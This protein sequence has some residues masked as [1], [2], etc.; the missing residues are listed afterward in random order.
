MFE[1]INANKFDKNNLLVKNLGA[2]KATYTNSRDQS[3][4]SI[5]CCTDHMR[6]AGGTYENP[7]L[8]RQ[9]FYGQA[10]MR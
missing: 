4:A 8:Y 2:S 6:P 3:R 1:K 7:R 10:M 9:F 5:T